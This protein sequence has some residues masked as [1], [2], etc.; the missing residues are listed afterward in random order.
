MLKTKGLPNCGDTCYFNSFLQLFFNIKEIQE[1]FDIY[2]TIETED[3]NDNESELI[4]ILNS[5]YIIYEFIIK[6]NKLNKNSSNHIITQTIQNILDL[7]F[8]NIG[9]HQD[10]IEVFNKL[11]SK[12]IVN[13]IKNIFL[14]YFS[15]ILKELF[16]NK[17]IC[18]DKDI[19]N[20]SYSFDETNFKNINLIDKIFTID[21]SLKYNYEY[22]KQVDIDI[23]SKYLII[24]FRSTTY[25]IID[26]ET[27]KLEKSFNIN[28]LNYKIKGIIIHTGDTIQSGQYYYL[29][30]ENEIC[31]KYDDINI[32]DNY[33]LIEKDDKYI[34]DNSN[35]PVIIIYEKKDIF[36]PT[37]ITNSYYKPIHINKIYKLKCLI[38][39]HFSRL[40]KLDK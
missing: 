26:Y 13:D 36:N 10:S 25:E 29:N 31:T 35:Q 1:Y 30:F 14:K 12:F 38:D 17:N 34:F 37:I 40:E 19:Y 6:D 8:T 18:N 23:K 16:T 4:L 39:K 3:K 33:I 24:S 7:K 11:I 2:I 9:I 28:N 27:I 22:Y 5:L 15:D 21:N 32:E 20:I